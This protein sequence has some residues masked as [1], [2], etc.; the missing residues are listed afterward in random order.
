[1]KTC[2]Q[3]SKT[4]GRVGCNEGI[5]S[6]KATPTGNRVRPA[7]GTRSRRTP[8]C[9]AR[10]DPVPSR[11]VVP[12]TATGDRGRN[13]ALATAPP[14]AP[15]VPSVPDH[16]RLVRVFIND[17]QYDALHRYSP[18]YRSEV[19]RWLFVIAA[20]L[21]SCD[22]KASFYGSGRSCATGVAKQARAGWCIPSTG[23]AG[24]GCQYEISPA[25]PSHVLACVFQCMSFE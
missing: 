17:K 20:R 15:S 13:A 19:L 8:R 18:G 9:C 1:M 5:V 16:P 2:A 6:R 21:P 12:E 22:G 25:G 7:P 23:G 14:A 3:E 24:A 4:L 10:R 11:G